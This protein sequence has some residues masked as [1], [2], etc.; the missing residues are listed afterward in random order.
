VWQLG[1]LA[2]YK[3]WAFKIIEIGSTPDYFETF[4]WLQL[5]GVFKILNDIDYATTPTPT[6]G[7]TAADAARRCSKQQESN[8]ATA[9]GAGIPF[10]LP[11]FT[12]WLDLATGYT[13]SRGASSG[14]YKPAGN[15]L[16]K[17]RELQRQL[18]AL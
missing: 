7:L 11:I 15:G 18:A 1:G 17:P 5:S 9:W 2:S 3:H 8:M 10:L 16:N 6:T 12:F 14:G 4:E 13:T